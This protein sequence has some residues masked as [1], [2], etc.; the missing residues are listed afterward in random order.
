MLGNAHDTIRERRDYRQECANLAYIVE[1]ADQKIG[2][3]NQL[4]YHNLVKNGKI[5]GIGEKLKASR[6]GFYRHQK[7]LKSLRS[8]LRE[9]KMS[10]SMSVGTL[11]L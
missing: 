10:L 2:K 5:E 9:I 7:K 11:T 3:I 8:E 6:V 4:I 1:R